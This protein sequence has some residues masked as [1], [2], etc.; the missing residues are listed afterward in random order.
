MH[1]LAN[2]NC[3]ASLHN[4]STC[5]TVASGLSNVWSIID[6]IVLSNSAPPTPTPAEIR[7]APLRTTFCT[8]SLLC[9]T[10]RLSV[11]TPSLQQVWAFVS[12]RTSSMSRMMVA[13]SMELAFK[14]EKKGEENKTTVQLPQF[15]KPQ[16]KVAKC[17]KERRYSR[18]VS[19]CR[20]K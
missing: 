13:L 10:Q 18:A 19:K 6:A 1:T 12:L 3:F 5:C 20:S 9:T 15:Q 8:P 14:I 2:P 4:C 16:R 11:Q 17:A 7:S